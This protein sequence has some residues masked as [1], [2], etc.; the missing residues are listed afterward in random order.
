M[1]SD[2]ILHVWSMSSDIQQVGNASE[3]YKA[4]PE[5][6]IELAQKRKKL[7]LKNYKL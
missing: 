4:L 1:K 3:V 6:T 2:G 7:P 5:H